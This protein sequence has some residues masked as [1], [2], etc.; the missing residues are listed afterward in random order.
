MSPSFIHYKKD[1]VK[2]LHSITQF[3]QVK[4]FYLFLR[5]SSGKLVF[6]DEI[7]VHLQLP[8]YG[9]ISADD[10]ENGT[11]AATCVV[12]LLLLCIPNLPY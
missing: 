12:D 4:P 5:K 6:P 11:K 10:F 1:I 9:T 3:E 2:H 8:F 7:D